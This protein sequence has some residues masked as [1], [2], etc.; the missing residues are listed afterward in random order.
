MSMGVNLSIVAALGIAWVAPLAAQTQQGQ[1][2][3]C[4]LR[5]AAVPET[6][7]VFALC[8]QGSYWSSRDAGATWVRGET[9][10]TEKLRAMAFLDAKRAFVVGDHGL[11]LASEDGGRKWTAR[12]VPTKQHLMDISFVGENGWIAGYQGVILHTKDGGRT[13][14]Q[15]QTGTTQTLET[16]FFADPGHGWVVGWA[17]TILRTSNGGANW[18]LVK[19]DAAS[20]SLSSAFFKDTQ[21]GWLVGFNGQIL[22]SR[23]GGATWKPL[24]SPVKSWLT[25]IAFDAANRGWITY[26][27]GLLLSEDG[28][29]TWKAVPADGRYFLAKL[30]RVKDSLWAIGQSAILRQDGVKW[31]KIGSLVPSTTGSPGAATPNSSTP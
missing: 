3:S 20:W 15:Q 6:S 27:D 24:T 29:E 14:E 8:E 21:N 1:G 18:E 4:W 7:V 31:V 22:R 13:W 5:D 23:D 19:C 9:G 12:A 16:I 17:G 28:G 10:A 2:R 11:V 26:D 25:N 30:Q